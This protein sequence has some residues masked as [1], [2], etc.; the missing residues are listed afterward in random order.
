MAR[1][2]V[3]EFLAVAA[4]IDALLQGGYEV[5]PPWDRNLN[6]G[7]SGAFT[8]EMRVAQQTIL[9]DAEYPSALQ[10]SPRVSGGGNQGWGVAVRAGVAAAMAVCCACWSC[11]VFCSALRY[12]S[13]LS[14]S[15]VL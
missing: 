9:H 2:C 10:L 13:A 15:A 6:T 5:L 7:Q 14:M 4:R 8:Q 3:G 12:F 11:S 1:P